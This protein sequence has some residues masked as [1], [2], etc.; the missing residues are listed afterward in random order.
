MN[1]EIHRDNPTRK[2]RSGLRRAATV[3]RNVAMLL[4]LIFL[5]GCHGQ[6]HFMAESMPGSLLVGSRSNPKEADLSRLASATGGSEII[7][8][9]DILEVNIA[10]G[11]SEDDQIKIPVRVGDDGTASL[12]DIGTVQLA[13]FEP[14]AAESLIRLS[15]IR[16]RLYQNPTVT[17][18]VTHQRM[19]RVRV[20]GAVLK[21]GVY[22]LPPNSSDIV[23][24]IAAAEGLAEDAGENVEIRNPARPASQRRAVASIDD[25]LVTNVSSSSG[26]DAI[27]SGGMNSYTVNLVSAAKAASGNYLIQDGGVVMVEKRDPAPIQVLG[28]VRS[29]GRYEFPIGQDLYLLDA[30]AL[31]G[32]LSNQLANKI[33]VIRPL[34]DSADPAVIQVS[35][36]TAKKSGAS[37]FRLAPGDV[38]SVEQTVSTVLMEALQIIRF[39]VTGSAFSGI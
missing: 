28:L 5:I 3:V 19:N 33:Y 30:L 24:A 1:H 22:E 15:S 37:N 10:A 29:P 12:P 17:V 27:V 13:G 8:P 23:S 14:Q 20:L 34:A 2:Q 18:T 16:Q 26:G 31:A 39:S 4:T 7:G 25:D 11:L 38:V 21:P 9:G 32:G 35:L 36:R 6:N